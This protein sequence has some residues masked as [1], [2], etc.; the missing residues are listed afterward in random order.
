M[1]IPNL[2]PL[3][4]KATFSMTDASTRNNGTGSGPVREDT[5]TQDFHFK[6]EYLFYSANI[7]GA[8]IMCYVLCWLEMPTNPRPWSFAFSHAIDETLNI[9]FRNYWRRREASSYNCP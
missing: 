1:E 3:G 6:K 4:F 8:L 5:Q 9:S 7:Y 2:D